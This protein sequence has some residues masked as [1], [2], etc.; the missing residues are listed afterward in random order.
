MTKTDAQNGKNGGKGLE[1]PNLSAMLTAGNLKWMLH[2][3]D[4]FLKDWTKPGLNSQ[5]D[6]TGFPDV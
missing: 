1:K 4:V 6:I 2:T 3:S 5:G